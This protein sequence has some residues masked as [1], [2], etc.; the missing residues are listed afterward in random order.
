MELS[1]GISLNGTSPPDGGGN[2]EQ[3]FDLSIGNPVDHA[4]VDGNVAHIENI[5][6]S[7]SSGSCWATVSHSHTDTTLRYYEVT[8][9]GDTPTSQFTPFIG[10]GLNSGTTFVGNTANAAGYLVGLKQV[11]MSTTSNVNAV[12]RPVDG[13]VIRMWTRGK[14]VWFGSYTD[15]IGYEIIGGG[16]PYTDTDPTK[17][18]IPDGDLRPIVT[19]H[20]AGTKALINTVG[21]FQHPPSSSAVAWDS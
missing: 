5:T 20:Y 1:L 15:G 18:I 3:G 17:I 6:A 7:N 4:L 19:C 10:Y 21:D 2:T 14:R 11:R 13:D 9:N 12:N 16:D 8:F